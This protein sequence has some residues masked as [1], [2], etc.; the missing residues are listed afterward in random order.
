M[1]AHETQQLKIMSKKEFAPAAQTQ[2]QSAQTEEK[3]SEDMKALVRALMVH[4][5]WTK[6]GLLDQ[7]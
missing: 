7:K 6:V 4:S 2:L 3:L 5:M 1:T